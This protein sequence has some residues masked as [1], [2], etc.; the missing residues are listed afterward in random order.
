M[1]L[2]FKRGTSYQC[3]SKLNCISWRQAQDGGWLATGNK[4]CGLGITSLGA[5]AESRLGTANFT[6]H[7]SEVS[8]D[9]NQQGSILLYI[10]MNLFVDTA[11]ALEGKC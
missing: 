10:M 9:S 6:D 3:S 11:G 1:Y 7:F 5:R 8:N 2:Y 4:M